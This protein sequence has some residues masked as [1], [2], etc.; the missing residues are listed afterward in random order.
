MY[1]VVPACANAAAAES[2]DESIDFRLIMEAIDTV[3]FVVV[4]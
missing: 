1:R 2:T 3:V 4:R